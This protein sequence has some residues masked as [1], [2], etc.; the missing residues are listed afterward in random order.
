[1]PTQLVLDLV[2]FASR[3]GPALWQARAERHRLV[4]VRAVLE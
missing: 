3:S 4:D 1:M 2:E